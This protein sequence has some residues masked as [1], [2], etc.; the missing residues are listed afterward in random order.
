MMNRRAI[1]E[2]AIKGVEINKE[3]FIAD[4][5][6]L[7]GNVE[8]SK[9]ASVWYGAV[10][11]GDMDYIFLGKASN[12]QDNVTIHNSKGYPVIIGENTSIG[13][14]A[15]VHGSKIGNNCLIGMGAIILNGAQI[16]D[17][18]I[19]G[20]GALVP[21]GMVVPEGYLALGVPARL[22]RELSQEEIEKIG[23]NAKSYVDHWK[24]NYRD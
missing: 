19:I 9:D 6:R 2:R 1:M 22:V 13:H 17:G 20:A 18:S 10:L 11:R 12:I 15:V 8:I 14:N 24:K 21:E 16:G 4:N 7:I 23:D 5:A 3:S